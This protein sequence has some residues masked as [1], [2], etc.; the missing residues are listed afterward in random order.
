MAADYD[1]ARARVSRVSDA[2]RTAEGT[3]IDL[4][5]SVPARQVGKPSLMIRIKHLLR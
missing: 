5:V 4:D 3:R 1:F 2:V